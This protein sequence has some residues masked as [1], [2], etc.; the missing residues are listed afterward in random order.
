MDLYSIKIDTATLVNFA[1]MKEQTPAWCLIAVN[2]HR[3]LYVDI[4][5]PQAYVKYL[6]DN[7][8]FACEVLRDHQGYREFLMKYKSKKAV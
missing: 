7:N 8:L 5:D 2:H 6:E 1:L 4:R 3:D